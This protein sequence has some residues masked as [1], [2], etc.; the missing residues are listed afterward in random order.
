MVIRCALDKVMGVLLNQNPFQFIKFDVSGVGVGLNASD[1]GILEAESLGLVCRLYC[2][3]LSNR[4][5]K[6][7]AG[8]L[9]LQMLRK[10]LVE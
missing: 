8:W 4:C 7:K 3:I 2:V 6:F 1:C 9:R 10:G 5:K